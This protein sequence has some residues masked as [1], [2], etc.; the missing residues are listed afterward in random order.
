MNDPFSKQQI[1][2]G[3]YAIDI[4]QSQSQRPAPVMLLIHGIGVS[5]TYFVPFAAECAPYY[6]VRII[7]MPGYGQTPKPDHVLS[8]QEMADIAAA[9][10]REGGVSR[11]I[12]VGQSMGCQTAAQ[13]ATHYPDLCA[14]LILI[15]PTVNI[16]ERS[17]F[18]QALRLLQ[19]TFMESPQAN[20]LVAR[21]Y[22]HM[23]ILR[24]L[25]TARHMM[26]DHIEEYL[27]TIKAPVLITRG[28]ND[29]ISPYEWI[30]KLSESTPGSSLGE[31]PG[32]AHVAQFTKPKEL[33]AQ[34]QKFLSA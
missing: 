3:K 33:F 22:A 21:D 26:L 34:C 28:A 13:L 19:D 11:A 8:P 4:R 16:K 17:V 9:Y 23:G 15:G 30:L 12:V 32:A 24:Y 25:K 6:D 10:L 7:D 2:V 1:R 18:I 14:K 20:V 5:G 27:P 29:K 31:I